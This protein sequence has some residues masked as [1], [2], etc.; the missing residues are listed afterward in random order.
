MVALYVVS[1]VMDVFSVIFESG[2][3]KRNR[4]EFSLM[5]ELISLPG[6][7]VF[8]FLLIVAAVILWILS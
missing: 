5:M 2:F 3:W 7:V 1:R 6:V 8:G 4:S